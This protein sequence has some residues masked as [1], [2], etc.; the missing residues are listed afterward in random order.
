MRVCFWSTTFQADNHALADHLAQAGWDVTVAL[1]GAARFAQEPVQRFLPFSG[2]LLE[3][4]EASTKA[5]LKREAFDLVIVDNHLPS[6]EIAP[7]LFVLWHGF[8]WRVDDLSTTRR[9]VKKLVGDV[10]LPNENFRFQAFGAWDREYRIRHS[11]LAPEN[12][13]ALGSAF[14]DWLRPESP[15]RARVDKRALQ[16]FYSLDLA[17]PVVLLGLTWHHGGSLG[18]WGDEE[19]L[20][21]RL[22]Q[23]VAARGASTLLRMHDRHRY[24]KDYQRLVERLA[25]R[26]AGKLMLKWKS[27]AP[28][29]LLDLLVSDVCISNY[30][31]LLN[32]FYYTERPSL[33]IDPHDASAA[34]QSTFTMFLGRPMRRSVTAPDELWK[35]PPE[36]HG[37]LR[38]QSF[39]EL[40]DQ[41][42]QALAEP[43]CCEARAR[44]FVARYITGADGATRERIQRYLT[45]WLSG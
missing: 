21:D 24:T 36:E 13:V 26:H 14:S 10:T 27:E 20:L 28:D 6:Y 41:V 39:P 25:E 11:Q 8:G 3:R 32:A 42:E 1:P 12:V 18:H 22:V 31:S 37:G 17:A 2:R 38:A 4:D 30:S 29:S 40:L 43:R 35:L 34:K 7:R 19:Q 23:H 15:L 5:A 16:P 9:E 44:E 45:G 33:H